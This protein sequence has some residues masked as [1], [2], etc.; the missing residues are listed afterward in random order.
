MFL[1]KTAGV[2]TVVML[3]IG[4]VAAQDGAAPGVRAFI[5]DLTPPAIDNGLRDADPPR[6]PRPYPTDLVHLSNGLPYLR[7]SIVVKFRPGTA[8][9]TQRVIIDRIGATTMDAPSYADFNIVNIDEN[10]DPEQAAATVAQQPDVEYAQARYLMH[11]MFTPNDP[12]YSEQWNFPA[13]DMERA[14]DLNPGASPSIIVAVIDSGVAYR[15]T[16]LRRNIP[17]WRGSDGVNVFN[18]PALG[19]VDIPFAAAP[20]LGGPDR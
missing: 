12:L 20:D 19:V 7:G 14:W 11:P 3:A 18:F 13:I 5:S 15:T 16:V 9:A 4:V 10:A 8:A 1:S 17:A 6:P 2:L